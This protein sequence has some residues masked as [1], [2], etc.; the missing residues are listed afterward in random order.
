[1]VRG[2]EMVDHPDMLE[3]NRTRVFLCDD[4]QEF[5]ALMRGVL[6]LDP[7]IKIVGE[8]GDGREG[9][10]GVAATQP[11][12]VLLDLSMP[13]MDGLQALPLMRE[14]APG[15]RII[16]LSGISRETAEDQVLAE[17]AD[18]YL[19]KGAAFDE[20][21]AAVRDRAAVVRAA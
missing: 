20:I 19:E 2:G 12:V 10:T 8:A 18:G 5:R 15:V 16:V 4:L 7:S 17:G 11:D 6:S 21:L 13:V 1:M 3:A 9:V 14:A